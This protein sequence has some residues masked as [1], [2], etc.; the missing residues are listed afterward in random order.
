M[1]QFAK[2]KE[3][4]ELYTLTP[5]QTRLFLAA[6]NIMRLY[7]CETWPHTKSVVRKLNRYYVRMPMYPEVSGVPEYILE[8]GT[9][10]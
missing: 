4:L 8:T 3:D 5:D 6:D 10:K 1:E 7:K 2:N 9:E